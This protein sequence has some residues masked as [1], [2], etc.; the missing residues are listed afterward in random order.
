MPSFSRRLCCL[1]G[2]K[3]LGWLA[4]R[5]RK[6]VF[7]FK[8]PKRVLRTRS[9]WL[10]LLAVAAFAVLLT[11]CGATSDLGGVQNFADTAAL[12]NTAAI[13]L[14]A[15]DKIHVIVYGEDN[16]TG[17]YQVDTGGYIALPLAG[18]VKAAGLTPPEL[19]KT[20]NTVFGKT[21]LNHP[22][23]TVEVMSFRPFYVLGEVQKPGEY[24]YRAGLN[25]LS[26]IAIAGGATYRASSSEVLIQRAGVRTLQKFPQSP[27][28]AVMPGDLVRVP[29]SIF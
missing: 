20:L 7:L 23:V 19:E 18:S 25:V 12:P 4:Y 28:V 6:G 21:S 16:I 8:A 14:E 9:S 11:S 27:E 17:N 13:K 26:A 22:R 1:R 10:T 15:G 24:P 2:I 5:P 3:S 29:E